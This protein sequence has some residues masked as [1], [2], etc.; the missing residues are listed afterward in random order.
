M[1]ATGVAR[2]RDEGAEEGDR[3]D[4]VLKPTTRAMKLDQLTGGKKMR[5]KGGRAGG[6][7]VEVRKEAKE[8]DDED[9]RQETR[10]GETRD[11][12]CCDE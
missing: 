12:R 3:R 6:R 1:T 2:R 7:R 4:S 10:D 5:L 8:E 11:D 9:K